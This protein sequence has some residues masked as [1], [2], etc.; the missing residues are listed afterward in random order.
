MKTAI[1]KRTC[2]ALLMGNMFSCDVL[3]VEPLDSYTEDGIFTDANLTESYVTM[4]YTKP[5]NGWSRSSLRFV[6]VSYTH[7]DVY[8]RQ[9]IVFAVLLY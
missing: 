7:L 8:K 1:L 9:Q 6:S 2:I 5:R 3:D 4:N